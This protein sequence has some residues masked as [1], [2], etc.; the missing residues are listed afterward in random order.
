MDAPKIYQLN[1]LKNII[2]IF[3]NKLKKIKCKLNNEKEVKKILLKIINE[4]PAVAENSFTFL[5]KTDKK[6]INVIWDAIN[7]LLHLNISSICKPDDTSLE[8]I[9]KY[10]NSDLLCIDAFNKISCLFND[11]SFNYKKTKNLQLVN[12]FYNK[13]LPKTAGMDIPREVP[14]LDY[15]GCVYGGDAYTADAGASAATS[16][17][18][19]LALFVSF[20]IASIINAS[21]GFQ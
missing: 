16:K 14:E 7:K 2:E 10:L 17:A 11:F 3:L 9:D 1:C 6:N 8:I 12:I 13:Q 5:V 19:D 21:E 4:N 18:E 20:I 15:Y